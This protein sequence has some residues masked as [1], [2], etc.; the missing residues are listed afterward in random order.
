MRLLRAKP[1]PLPALR[2]APSPDAA[3]GLPRSARSAPPGSARPRSHR[4][5][6]NREVGQ[7]GASLRSQL[8]RHAFTLRINYKREKVTGK[9]GFDRFLLLSRVLSRALRLFAAHRGIVR[10][11][12]GRLTPLRCEDCKGTRRSA[13]PLARLAP[14]LGS[15]AV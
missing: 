8:P 3:P 10:Q 4:T 11:P 5:G 7:T 12:A 14:A 13:L 1:C 15:E 9:R 6:A 2:P